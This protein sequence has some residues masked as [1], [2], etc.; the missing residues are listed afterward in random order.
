MSTTDVAAAEEMC[1]AN[2]GISAIDDIK[3][4]DCDGGCGLVKYCSDN[5]QKNHSEQHEEECKKRMTEL[6]D[7][8]L[9]EQPDSSDLGECPIC[10]LLLPIDPTKFA[11]YTCCSKFI[12][13][14]CQYAN[15]KREIEAGLE[16]RCV[17]V[18]S[19]CQTRMKNVTRD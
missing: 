8:D 3:L 10:C 12:C 9:F 7:D 1:C 14:G 13:R 19:H 5:C 17:S 4:M 18:E 11:F 16:K 2:C 6:R 15:E